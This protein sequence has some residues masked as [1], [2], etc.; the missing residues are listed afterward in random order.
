M[1]KPLL[2]VVRQNTKLLNSIIFF[3]CWSQLHAHAN[4]LFLNK[5]ENVTPIMEVSPSSGRNI[6]SKSPEQGKNTPEISDSKGKTENK[7]NIQTNTAAPTVITLPETNPGANGKTRY[8]LSDIK[9]GIIG[10]D[11]DHPIDQVYDNIF[12]ISLDE[13][14]NPEYQYTLEYDLYGATSY[15]EVSKVINDELAT[16]GNNLLKNEGWVHQSEPVSVS[17]VH[18][19]INTIIFT[20]PHLSKSSYKVRNLQ[21]GVSEKKQNLGSIGEK[22]NA[23]TISKFIT[24]IGGAEKLNLGSA[25]LA[26]PQGALKSSENFSITALRDIDMPALSPE[27]VNVTLQMQDIDSSL[28][29]SI[30]RL[31][32]K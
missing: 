8:Y 26:I 31:L 32:Q 10:T 30:F 23:A 11:A 29:V 17:S 5:G 14:I 6:E 28:M 22:Y 3:T 16:G 21:I 13:K 24:N 4:S 12:T 7:N 27:M 20:I 1:R 2:S 15:K 25:G 9:E 18:Q 19:G